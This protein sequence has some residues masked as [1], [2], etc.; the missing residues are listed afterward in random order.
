LPPESEID[1]SNYKNWLYYLNLYQIPY[2]DFRKAF[3]AAKDSTSAPLF[4]NQGIH[5]STYGAQFALDSVAAYLNSQYGFNGPRRQIDS[6]VLSENYDA[7]E[8][9]IES[10]LNLLCP[11]PRQKLAYSSNTFTAGT[12][13]RLLMI[14]DSFFFQLYGSGF[15]NQLFDDPLFYYY[16]IRALKYSE[17]DYPEDPTAK[18]LKQVLDYID[19]VC[20]MAVDI[21]LKDFPW[22][23]GKRF[24][25]EVLGD[26]IH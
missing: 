22:A 5:W 19:V 23:F 1:S 3:L 11:M 10:S 12:K 21:N 25:V 20:L 15:A 4:S 8:Y 18:S 2:L 6:L 14:S 26:S 16:H 9:D 17:I 24:E 7:V 13:P